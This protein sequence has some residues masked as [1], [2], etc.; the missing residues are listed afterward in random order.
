MHSFLNYT[1]LSIVQSSKTNPRS[2]NLLT[3]KGKLQHVMQAAGDVSHDTLSLFDT[4]G[5]KYY[6]VKIRFKNQSNVQ[7]IS[8]SHSAM[9]LMFVTA[10]IVAVLGV[11]T[12]ARGLGTGTSGSLK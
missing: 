11:V 9:S 2:I 1:K 3:Q 4:G 12:L 5:D 6:K 10:V 8:F 7:I